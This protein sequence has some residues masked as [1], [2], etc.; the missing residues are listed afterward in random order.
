MF[1]SRH[2]L[3]LLFLVIGMVP[4]SPVRAGEAPRIWI[5]PAKDE[6]G[7]RT[8]H[9]QLPGS[10]AESGI[11]FGRSGGAMEEVAT[12]RVDGIFRADVDVSE[13][14]ADWQFQIDGDRIRPL[15]G[16]EKGGIRI[17][18]VADWHGNARPGADAIL[19]DRPHLLVTAGDNVTSLHAPGREG[20][21][22]YSAL[23]DSAPELFAS[24][25]VRPSV[26]NHDNE[27]RPR[28]PKPPDDDPVYDIEATVLRQFFD[29]PE[30]GWRWKLASPHHGLS[31][32][33]L[34]L[35]HL[36]DFGSHWQSGHAFDAKSE[37]SHWL[38]GVVESDSADFTVFLYNEKNS[39]VRAVSGGAFGE[40]FQKRAGAV[41]TGFGGFSERAEWKG[42]PSYNVH[43][44]GKGTDYPDQ[45]RAFATKEG[46]YLLITKV[47]GEAGMILQIK[48]HDGRVL[49]TREVRERGKGSPESPR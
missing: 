15:R 9:W 48:S 41:V 35:H 32:V 11:R 27:I 19:R 14:D 7:K 46:A 22:A 3:P 17:V 1:L 12:R 43:I 38:Q 42:M 5:T 4:H 24:V 39:T 18:A 28:G 30:N 23:I 45:H 33:G 21:L 16:L 6:L 37:Q 2:S 8:I 47:A 31:L 44:H 36:S 20:L 25:P 29:L 34:D 40:A 49:D 10:P 13:W 26:G